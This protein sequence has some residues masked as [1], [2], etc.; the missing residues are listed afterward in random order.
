MNGR[1][2]TLN[3]EVLELVVLLQRGGGLLLRLLGLGLGGG[4][5]GLVVL[6]GL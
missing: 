3:W 4:G 2:R 6:L 1:S 5:G